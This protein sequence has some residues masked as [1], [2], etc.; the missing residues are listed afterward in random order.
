MIK[1]AIMRDVEHR[2]AKNLDRA[3]VLIEHTTDAD[4]KVTITHW[5]IKEK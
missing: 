3:D 4:D 5:A 1:D 2:I